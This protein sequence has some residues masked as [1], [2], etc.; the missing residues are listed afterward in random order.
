MKRIF[1]GISFIV[2]ILLLSTTFVYADS[3][4]IGDITTEYDYEYI[5]DTLKAAGFFKGTTNGY[6]LDRAPS[7]VEAAVMLVRMLGK[8]TFV[9]EN[10]F[11]HPFTD[12]PSWADA[13]VG[14]LYTN[15]LTSGTSTT[16]Y[17]SE[18][19]I[20]ANQYVTFLLRSL[21]YDDSAGDFQWNQAVEKAIQIQLITRE[22]ADLI[23]GATFLRSHTALL[24]YL[25]LKT[26]A[27]GT[28]IPLISILAE[29]GD[30]SLNSEEIILNNSLRTVAE[31][32]AI[33]VK[34]ADITNI[35]NAYE[36]SNIRMDSARNLTVQQY[37]SMEMEDSSSDALIKSMFVSSDITYKIDIG[38]YIASTEEHSIIDFDDMH[39]EI[40]GVSYADTEHY[41]VYTAP[42]DNFGIMT[43]AIFGDVYG[44]AYAMNQYELI[45]S[46][47]DAVNQQIDLVDV[48]EEDFSDP[49]YNITYESTDTQYIISIVDMDTSTLDDTTSLIS[50]DAVIFDFT[51]VIDKELEIIT[52]MAMNFTE[53]DEN[54][55][56]MKGVLIIDISD[57]NTTQVE[58]PVEIQ[59]YL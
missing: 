21:N 23:N 14:Y 52:Q 55:D 29:R 33:A 16:T 17:G 36:T 11:D 10:A 12:V 51:I 46:M 34:E 40:N 18:D 9:Q 8:E 26:N 41:Y 4:L 24:T 53:T 59:A 45:F 20:T 27:K 3:S 25:G 19:M 37:V 44:D 39:F 15:G 47:Y 58:I 6:E 1:R 22:Q 42:G 5:A 13:Y 2:A 43:E 32:A 49:A 54:G 35:K 28:E 57:I 38:K 31:S 7:R 30:I 56:A 48:L 50:G